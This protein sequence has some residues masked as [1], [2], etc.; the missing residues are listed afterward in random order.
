MTR[1]AMS[2]DVDVDPIELPVE[3]QP[4]QG[5]SKSTAWAARRSSFESEGPL[6][7][8]R[9]EPGVLGVLDFPFEPP[10]EPFE[11][12]DLLDHPEQRISHGE[13]LLGPRESVRALS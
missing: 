9:G 12:P 11:E 13:P 3:D 1:A 2:V 10:R 4:P 8:R 6:E 5:K 7:R